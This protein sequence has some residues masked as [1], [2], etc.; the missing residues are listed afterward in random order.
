MKTTLFTVVTCMIAI[1]G[2]A[3]TVGGKIVDEQRQPMPF[4][5]VVAL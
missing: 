5:N 1:N 2:T 3:Q 4:V